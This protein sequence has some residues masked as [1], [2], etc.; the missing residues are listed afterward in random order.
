MAQ[1]DKSDAH[2]LKMRMNRARGFYGMAAS[3][4]L[5]RHVDEAMAEALEALERK[6][7]EEEE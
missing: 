4:V 3:N 6:Q 7:G 1:F 2:R 5:L